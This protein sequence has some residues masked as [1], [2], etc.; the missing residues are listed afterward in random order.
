MGQFEKLNPYDGDAKQWTLD[1][2]DCPYR[3]QT[4]RGYGEPVCRWGVAVKV[5][6]Q[7]AERGRHCEY[8]YR[9]PP[10]GSAHKLDR[11][12]IVKAKKETAPQQPALF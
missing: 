10:N 3:G 12:L 9:Q 1:C 5:L 4:D 8:R 6:Y 2:P 11:Q 7:N